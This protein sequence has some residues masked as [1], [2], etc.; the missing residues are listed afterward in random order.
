MGLDVGYYE[1]L[2]AIELPAG[3][4]SSDDI[5]EWM[6]END[7][8]EVRSG[9]GFLPRLDDLRPAFYKGSGR[10]GSFRAG[11]YGGY[12]RWRNELCQVM[13]GVNARVVWESPS[14]WSD[15]EFYELI[16][17]SDCEGFIG[18]RTCAKLARDFMKN[19]KRFV[20]SPLTTDYDAQIY[21]KFQ[22]AF[23]LASDTG[24]VRFF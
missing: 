2:D 9:D 12:N 15:S 13:L 23:V 22:A 19:R 17:F 18:P 5:Q 10:Q 4:K 21:D 14:K 7:V 6:E 20:Q 3:A 11:S 8:I 1:N 16:D 24:C